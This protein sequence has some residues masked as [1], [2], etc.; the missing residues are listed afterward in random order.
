MGLSLSLALLVAFRAGKMRGLT[1]Q[2]FEE[3]IGDLAFDTL[4]GEINAKLQE[5]FNLYHEMPQGQNWRCPGRFTINRIAT[6]LH[7]D[8]ETM[9]LLLNIYLDLTNQGVASEAFLQA[10]A[11]VAGPG[12]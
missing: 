7:N 5:C 2:N 6:H 11:F 3:K 8:T 1:D 12:M 4:K 10:L 9:E